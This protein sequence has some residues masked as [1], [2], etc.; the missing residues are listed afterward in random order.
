MESIFTYYNFKNNIGIQSGLNSRHKEINSLT[1]PMYHKHFNLIRLFI[2]LM[3]NLN[4]THTGCV[5]KFNGDLF[6]WCL[7][8]YQ[9]LDY[10]RKYWVY[11]KRWSTWQ[12]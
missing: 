7:L 10:K 1:L 3:F 5:H 9:E 2:T 8:I 4:L 6:E 12:D 11:V